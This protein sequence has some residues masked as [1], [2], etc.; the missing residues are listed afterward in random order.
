MSPGKAALPRCLSRR[1]GRAGPP[2]QA[3]WCTG[4]LPR[5]R[6]ILSRVAAFEL[7]K[8]GPDST[9][10]AQV[11]FWSGWAVRADQLS[12]ARKTVQASHAA[13]SLI[14]ASQRPIRRSGS[15]C[16][17]SSKATLAGD[18][19]RRLQLLLTSFVRTDAL[20]PPVLSEPE[21]SWR[22]RYGGVSGGAPRVRPMVIHGLTQPVPDPT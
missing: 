3:S 6:L 22:S 14:P 10:K 13:R 8:Q 9:L 7:L 19:A 18:R 1:T 16:S 11:P 20:V 5:S 17:S 15:A 21:R 4:Y 2:F 12:R